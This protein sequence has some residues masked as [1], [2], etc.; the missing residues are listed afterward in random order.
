MIR[1]SDPGL[2]QEEIDAVAAVLRTGML[3]Q[4]P[5]VARFEGVIAERTQRKHAIAVANGTSA[6]ELS[7]R[8]L[9]VGPGDEVIVPAL[10]W[11]SPAHAIAWLGA[12]PVLIDVDASTWNSE[13]EAYRR[14]LTSKTKAAIA[15]DQFGNPAPIEEIELFLPGIP[16]IEDAACAIGST[17]FDV[18]CAKKSVLATLSFHPRK[19]VTT[20]EGGM[21]LTDDDALADCLRVMRNH[22]QRAP[23]D[24]VLPGPNLRLA[25]PA[26]AIGIEQMKKLDAMIAARTRLAARYQEALPELSFQ[27]AIQGAKPNW[28]TL[29]VRLAEHFTSPMRDAVVDGIRARGVE[30]GKLSYALH[31]QPSLAAAKARAMADGR[32]FPN[33]EALANRGFA[34]PMWPGL[35]DADQSTVISAVK[36]A[37]DAVSKSV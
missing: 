7:L 10:S 1:L 23:G 34:L 29:G 12:L 13:P 6:L 37:L 35:S 27:A 17:R 36:S 30:C 8:A 24:F 14:A 2:G 26:A 28:Q 18:S 25:E 22:G 15:I 33:T 31:H 11:P 20:G 9:G 21:V 3:V 19:V 5:V 4:G 32:I 16:V